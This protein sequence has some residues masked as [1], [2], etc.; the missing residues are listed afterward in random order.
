MPDMGLEHG[1]SPSTDKQEATAESP[2]E[3]PASFLQV[4]P[5]G[6]PGQIFRIGARDGWPDQK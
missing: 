4:A 5:D 2:A 1:K 3:A 6:D